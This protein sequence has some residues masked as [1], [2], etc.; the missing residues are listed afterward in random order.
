M[1]SFKDYIESIEPYNKI[2]LNDLMRRLNSGGLLGKHI[3]ISPEEVKELV[4]VADAANNHIKSV[5]QQ[6]P[7]LTQQFQQYQQWEKTHGVNLVRFTFPN[8]IVKNGGNIPNI[9][10]TDRNI[11]VPE[12][13]YNLI[14][15][16]KIG[17][18]LR[19]II[20]QI[21]QNGITDQNHPSYGVD[22]ATLQ[23]SLSQIAQL[24]K[25]APESPTTPSSTGAIQSQIR[26]IINPAQM[27]GNKW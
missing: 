12:Q 20:K 25:R 23:K 10:A 1:R 19:N 5:L 26:Q 14:S 9:Q 17:I 18:S 15:W 24:F 4:N 16:Q 2:I 21:G 3:Q 6:S 27:V 11:V 7:Q 13:L 8:N 22:S